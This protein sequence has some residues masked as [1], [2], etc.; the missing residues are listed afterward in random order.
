MQGGNALLC[1]KRVGALFLL[2]WRVF[3]LMAKKWLVLALAVALLGVLG[4]VA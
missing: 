3:I 1:V 2:I 4:G